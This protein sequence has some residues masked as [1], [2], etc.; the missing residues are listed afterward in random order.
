M[1]AI[2]QA[3]KL[4]LA[5]SNNLLNNVFIQRTSN[6]YNRQYTSSQQQQQSKKFIY[7]SMA[8]AIVVSG[9]SM[10]L[11]NSEDDDRLYAETKSTFNYPDICGKFGP[12]MDR[13]IV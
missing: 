3:S 10:Y 13:T 2:K 7:G 9:V 12:E 6:G 1:K 8:A 5:R 11:L 4:R